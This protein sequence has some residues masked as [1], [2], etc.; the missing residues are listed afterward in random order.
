MLVVLF[1]LGGNGE[2]PGICTEI[3]GGSSDDV[4]FSARLVGSDKCEFVKR[5]DHA[6]SWQRRHDNCH[7]KRRL[8]ETRGS[9]E[10]VWEMEIL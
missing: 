9:P 8:N 1:S 7:D 3:W 6:A 4:F 5:G 2:M 10:S